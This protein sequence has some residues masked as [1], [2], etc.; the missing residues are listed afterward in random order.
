MNRINR[1]TAILTQLQSKR[2][3]TAQTIAN[4][5]EI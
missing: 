5:F 3:V 1:I 2:I 4:R